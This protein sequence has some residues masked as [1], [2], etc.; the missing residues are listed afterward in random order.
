MDVSQFTWNNERGCL[1]K[2]TASYIRLRLRDNCTRRGP[3]VTGQDSNHRREKMIKASF[4]IAILLLSS[5]R[6]N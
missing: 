5:N 2:Y 1:A 6:F 3:N 4:I